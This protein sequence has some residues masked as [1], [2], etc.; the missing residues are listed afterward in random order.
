[1]IGNA[2]QISNPDYVPSPRAIVM[3]A[4]F[5][6]W[7]GR[8]IMMVIV[9]MMV[10]AYTV[11]DIPDVVGGQYGQP[12]GSLCLRVL[13]KRVGLALFSLN[14]IAQFFCGQGCT[15]AAKV[16]YRLC[17]LARWSYCGVP[18]GGRRSIREQEPR[19]MPHGAC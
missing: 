2:G 14:M 8:A 10:I 11:K 5:G 4:H 12:F 6:L 18:D 9:I 13:G 3:T 16:P 19:G 7:L 1:M 17:V 15:I